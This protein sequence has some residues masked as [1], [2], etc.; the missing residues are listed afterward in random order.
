[1]DVILV[2]KVYADWCGH[3]Q[4]LKPEWLKMKKEVKSLIE[5]TGKTIEFIEIEESQQEK[6][7]DFK[8]R[9]P[10]LSVNGYP[11]IFKHIKGGDH[12]EYYTGD[13]EASKMCQWVLGKKMG[14][15]K[16]KKTVKRKKMRK[17]KTVHMRS[18][19]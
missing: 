12:L 13:R 3:C 11:T 5:K 14:G 4:N 6:M 2:G 10:N 8:E 9:F 15:K 7:D 1:M 19:K 18:L 17:N 16:Q